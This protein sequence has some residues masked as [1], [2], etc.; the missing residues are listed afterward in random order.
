M[1]EVLALL[2]FPSGLALLAV[3][4]AYSWANRKLLARYQSRVGPPWY[5]PYAD[6]VKLLSKEDMP[7]VGTNRLLF[8]L[9][10][11]LGLAGSLTAALYLPLFGLGSSY[12][13]AGD[14]IVVLYLLSLSSFALGLVGLLV[15]SRV[16]AV[17]SSRVMSQL[18]AYEAP[19]LLALL[20]AAYGLRSWQISELNAAQQWGIVSQPL[21][22]LVLLIS[23]MGKLELPPFDAPEAET[24]IVGGALTEY[25]GRS[26]ALFK[27]AKALSFVLSVSLASVLYL[28]GLANPLDFLLKTL[29]LLFLIT[30][31]EA[32]FT[33]FRI[34]QSLKLWWRYA[35]AIAL[36]QWLMVLVGEV[37]A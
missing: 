18:F 11:V 8:Q 21:G 10:P 25:S 4:L 13:F 23:L 36:V 3:A 28:G 12:S 7:L 27:L 2:F 34:D 24:E 15:T 22:F 6:T 26:L 5:Q 32:L 1:T 29:A 17:G 20:A 35:L 16:G 9:L 30:S 31:I 33:R 19:Y 14:F 37:L